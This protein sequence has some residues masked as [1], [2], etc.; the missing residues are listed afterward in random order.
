MKRENLAVTGYHRP[1]KLINL[2]TYQFSE[3]EE[4]SFLLDEIGENGLSEVLIE[5]LEKPRLNLLGFTAI[6][7]ISVEFSKLNTPKEINKFAQKYGLLG[8]GDN[9]YSQNQPA[10][11]KVHSF[12]YL[13]DWE[14]HI[15][16]VKQLLNVYM[17]LERESEDE[18]ILEVCDQSDIWKKDT[19]WITLPGITTL[20]IPISMDK[21]AQVISLLIKGITEGFAGGID[22]D[23]SRIEPSKKSPIG[24]S[25]IEQ[26]QTKYL[27]VAIYFDLWQMV[28][29][30][31]PI[32]FCQNPNCGEII[33][34]MGKDNRYCNGACKTAA[35]EYRKEQ[36]HGLWKQ[37]KTEEEI[38]ELT[39]NSKSSTIRKWITEWE[40]DAA[41]LLQ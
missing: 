41:T 4:K 25:A 32:S 5:D 11:W 1:A 16:R 40:Q 30:K 13:H 17:T 15:K 7:G 35:Y 18:I 21:K 34:K 12:E 27:L 37:G 8:I 10:A 36:C 9:E 6:N 28:S 31:E 33:K 23:F 39:K 29:N 38:C 2:D 20:N 24:Y 19:Q 14:A 22:I 26:K 3:N